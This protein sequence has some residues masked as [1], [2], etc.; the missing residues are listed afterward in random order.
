MFCVSFKL[1]AESALGQVDMGDVEMKDETKTDV[2]DMSSKGS[3]VMS[4]SVEA[5]V[6]VEEE[7]LGCG[8]QGGRCGCSL[9]DGGGQ[10]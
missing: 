2:S 5:E 8:S 6:V 9:A 7:I 3:G 4:E 10:W 1:P